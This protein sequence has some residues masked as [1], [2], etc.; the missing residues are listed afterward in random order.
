[1]HQRQERLG[2]SVLSPLQEVGA[3]QRPVHQASTKEQDPLGGVHLGRTPYQL[4]HANGQF[5]GLVDQYRRRQRREPG[6]LLRVHQAD[7]GGC[8][9]MELAPYQVLEDGGAV[10]EL[11]DIVELK[12]RHLADPRFLLQ[13]FGGSSTKNR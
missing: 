11:I 9:E 12:R 6:S 2:A 1:V 13:A 4:T 8:L 5:A 7:V 3:H 10:A